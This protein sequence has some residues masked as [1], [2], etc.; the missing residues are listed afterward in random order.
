[1]ESHWG[2]LLQNAKGLIIKNPEV[3]HKFLMPCL[4]ASEATQA[5]REGVSG[6]LFLRNQ[7][8]GYLEFVVSVHKQKL[9]LKFFKSSATGV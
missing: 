5:L 4:A 9:D 7:V 1:M 2:G 6:S 8:R 3:A